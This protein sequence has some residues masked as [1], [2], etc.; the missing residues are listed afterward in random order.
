[1]PLL[2]QFPRKVVRCGRT[3]G[4]AERPRGSESAAILDGAEHSQHQHVARGHV[5]T[6][7]G[8]D[9]VQRSISIRT[10]QFSH[11]GMLADRVKTGMPR[12]PS[13]L[14]PDRGR[15]PPCCRS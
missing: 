6:R 7:I 15:F 10:G 8:M 1:V 13:D 3:G 4:P 14:G 9:F 5:P 11:A 2:L 12:E